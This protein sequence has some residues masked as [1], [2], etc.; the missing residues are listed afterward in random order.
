[1]PVALVFE[2]ARSDI[3]VLDATSFGSRVRGKG[4]RMSLVVPR[5]ALNVRSWQGTDTSTENSRAV[6]RS[7]SVSV[8]GGSLFGNQSLHL[9]ISPRIPGHFG[10]EGELQS[11]AGRSNRQHPDG[12]CEHPQLRSTKQ[13]ARNDPSPT[14]YCDPGTKHD[15]C[16]DRERGAHCRK[17]PTQV[18]E[19]GAHRH[20]S[21]K[22][23]DDSASG[24]RM[25]GLRARRCDLLNHGVEKAT[26]A[27]L[28]SPGLFREEVWS[29]ASLV[30]RARLELRRL[31]GDQEGTPRCTIPLCRGPS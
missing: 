16:W 5:T 8:A 24:Y 14:G 3:C 15:E 29:T 19:R 25:T 28:S 20:C 23:N 1:M 12:Y 13:E 22:G 6:W 18:R 9:L 26:E 7:D 10:W 2:D 30:S 27:F 21:E 31:F 4:D 11:P 17:R